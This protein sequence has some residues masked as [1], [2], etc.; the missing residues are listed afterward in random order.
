[1][2]RFGAEGLGMVEL[3]FGML[4]LTF[5]AQSLTLTRLVM[6]R[7]TL[8]QEQHAFAGL[9]ALQMYNELTA[10]ANA[11]PW[12]GGQVL[13]SYNDGVDYKLNL[14]ADKAISDP[15]DPLS[16]NRLANGHWV[17][18]RRIQ[19]S[20]TPSAPQAR[21]VTIQL[22]RCASDQVPLVPG[23]LLATVSGVITPGAALAEPKTSD[24]K[25]QAIE[26][27]R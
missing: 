17:Y 23:L 22:W 18:L 11:A 3:L 8:S 26:M 12:N 14:S 24:W 13:D 5:F 16:G 4:I 1:M 21:Q 19:V 25:T 20:P 6:A 2:K 7:K 9:K 10:S 15:G 27:T